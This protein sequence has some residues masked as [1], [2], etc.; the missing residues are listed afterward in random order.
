MTELIFNLLPILALLE[1]GAFIKDNGDAIGVYQIRPI[2]VK[3]INRIA[4]TIYNH[5]DAR[6]ERVAKQ[7]VYIY[8]KYYS[9]K[10]QERTGR[11]PS[12]YDLAMIFRKGPFGYAIQDHDYGIR[13]E[14]IYEDNLMGGR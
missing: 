2:F 5:E 14:N 11:V 3:D 7:M 6:D 1:T 8:L 9:K 10:M 4:K 13:A 12:V